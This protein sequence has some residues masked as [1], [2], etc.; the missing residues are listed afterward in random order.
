L[1]QAEVSTIIPVNMETELEVLQ[2]IRALLH[3]LTFVFINSVPEN[4]QKLT[5]HKTLEEL[6]EKIRKFPNTAGGL[7]DSNATVEYEGHELSYTDLLSEKDEAR[8]QLTE[9]IRKSSR[10]R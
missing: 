1:K 6:S 2:D 9:L 4:E 3:D 7:V 8:E 10:A 5:L